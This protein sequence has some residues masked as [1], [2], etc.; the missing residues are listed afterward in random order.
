[1]LIQP[2]R[3][4]LPMERTTF[5]TK[6]AKGIAVIT[7]KLTLNLLIGLV[8]LAPASLSADQIEKVDYRLSAWKSLHFKDAKQAASYVKTFKSIGVEY[9]QESHG[10]HIDVTFRCPKWRTLKLKT[11]KDAHQWEAF[12]KKIGF[13]TKH[14]H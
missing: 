10:D 7:H 2:E 3:C 4:S 1:M 13:E 14:D 11:H 6:A 9:K 8:L 12:L 5:T